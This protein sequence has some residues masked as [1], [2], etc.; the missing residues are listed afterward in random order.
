MK[1]QNEYLIVIDSLKAPGIYK[2]CDCINSFNEL[3]MKSISNLSI[4]ENTIKFNNIDFEYKIKKGKVKD[5]EQIFYYITISCNNE[6]YFDAF[7]EILKKIKSTIKSERTELETFRDD[8]TF[9]YARI[10]YSLIHNL[11]NKMRKLINYYMITHVGTDWINSN[12]PEEIK[13]TI[14]TSKRKEFDI[15]HRLDFIDLSKF[16]FLAYQTKEI[17]ELFK[18][19]D[20]LNNGDDISEL[21][22]HLPSSNWDKYFKNIIPCE[23]DFLKKRWESLYDLRNKIAHNAN[24]NIQDYENVQKMVLEIEEKIDMALTAIDELTVLEEVRHDTI[25]TIEPLDTTLIAKYFVE[26]SK[27]EIFMRDKANE[28]SELDDYMSDYMQTIKNAHSFDD[29][30]ILQ[31]EELLNFKNE[32]QQSTS[33]ITNEK[34]NIKLESLNSLNSQILPY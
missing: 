5:K 24:F 29:Q 33:E 32:L 9:Y 19:I 16:F 11:E 1:L 8:F 30:H 34:I 18:L 14:N 10:A 25:T 12:S 23:K 28:I 26:L 17:K 27:L 13:D 2:M 20:T 4:I 31:I 21:K 3:L 15:L 6:D 22:K 7:K